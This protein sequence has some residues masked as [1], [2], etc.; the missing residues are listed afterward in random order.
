MNKTIDLSGEW[1]FTCRPEHRHPG[2]KYPDTFPGTMMIPGFWDDHYNL[3]DYTDDFDRNATFNPEYRPIHF[4]MGQVTPDASKPFIIGTGYYRKKLKLNNVSNCR[5]RISIGPAIWGSEI[6]CNGVQVGYGSGYSTGY[7]YDLGNLLKDGDNEIVIAVSNSNRGGARDSING[8]HRGCAV[9]GY[10]STRA[11][12]SRGV[13]LRIFDQ[14]VITDYCIALDQNRLVFQAQISG[15]TGTT[16]YHKISFSGNTLLENCFAVPENGRICVFSD[17]ITALPRWSDRDPV[18]CN[19]LLELRD[20]NGV[21]LDKL[22]TRCGF[23]EM[24]VEKFDILLN[25]LPTFLRGSTEHCYFPESCNPHCDFDKY[26]RDLAVLKSAGFNFMRCHTWCPPEEFFSAC[27]QLGMIIQLE[28]PPNSTPEEWCAILNMARKHVSARILCG[29]NEENLTE[30]RIAILRDLQRN[31]KNLAPWMLFNPQEALPLAEYRLEA[32]PESEYSP[33]DIVE[34]PF[35]HNRRKFAQIAE[36]SDLYGGFNW[37][38]AS[39]F[40]EEFPGVEAMEKC[41]AVYEKPC[42]SHEA[43]ILG[44]YIDL[45]LETRYQNTYITPELYT[46]IREYQA[47][48]GVSFERSQYFYDL[49]SRFI[50]SL[51]KQQLENLRSCPTLRGYDFLGGV[52][53]HW[54]RCG[55]PCGVFNEFY[56]AKPGET[57]E[58]FRRCNGE[59]I[60]VCDAGFQRNLRAGEKFSHR[61][62]VSYFDSCMRKD[63]V[64]KWSFTA[65]NF[66]IADECEVPE[67]IPG[68]VLPL[69]IVSFKLPRFNSAVKGVLRCTLKN[70]DL[71]IDNEWNFWCFPAVSTVDMPA[72]CAVSHKFGDNELKLLA[73]GGR[74]L[75]L[76]DFPCE[77]S[78]EFYRPCSTGRSNGHYGSYVNKHPVMA[79]FPN[80]GFLEFQIFNMIYPNGRALLFN[81]DTALP[82]EPVIGLIP[83]YKLHNQKALLVEYAVG[84][85][86]LILCSLHLD[87]D[88]P[89]A[90]FL[91][92]RLLKYLTAGKFARAAEVSLETLAA[93]AKTKFGV[94]AARTTDIA[95]DPNAA[96]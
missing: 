51:R 65:G 61:I 12:I 78:E 53:A 74:L 39:Y 91:K 71:Q 2:E 89:A 79:E 50:A 62:S 55:Y 54:H 5:A 31:M 46:K 87:I 14:A 30:S 81:S 43:G 70:Q 47:A 59:S 75:L 64:M 9:R 13:T 94:A 4:P 10:K 85:G 66:T 86:R 96:K 90:Q 21:L 34:T 84:K 6:F 57:A 67:L 20:K 80:D 8:Q 25:G 41:L 3:F 18:L 88:D 15:T 42:L 32:T 63:S 83:P 77:S 44:G 37:G 95:W 16:L 38:Y 52:D 33:D 76:D 26:C 7:E 17:A 19:M 11:G 48:N 28:V 29:G 73:D 72:N 1:E 23:A 56:E 40:P 69:G 92:S 58:S 35:P 27:D 82:F 24:Y 22:E 68:K 93:A 36:F 45:S 49:N 60:L